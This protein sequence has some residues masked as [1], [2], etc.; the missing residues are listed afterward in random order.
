MNRRRLNMAA[1]LGAFL[2]MEAAAL[3]ATAVMGAAAAVSATVHH[4]VPASRRTAAR[5]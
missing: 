2:A 3:V 1:E 4:V 5:P